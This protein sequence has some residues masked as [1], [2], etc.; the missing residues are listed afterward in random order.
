[1]I[2]NSDGY[3][4]KLL[5]DSKL[6]SVISIKLDADL[7]NIGEKVDIGFN[8]EELAKNENYK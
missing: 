4:N 3:L 1:V 8:P 2:K 7:N 6:Y 5:I